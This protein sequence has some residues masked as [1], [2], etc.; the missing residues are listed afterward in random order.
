MVVILFLLSS[1]PFQHHWI[2]EYTFLD[3]D[4]VIRPS[5]L[6]SY[7]ILYALGRPAGK[8]VFLRLCL[9]IPVLIVS[10]MY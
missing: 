2:I 8:Q 4:L 9:T 6:L 5:S 10:F 3:L 7:T 1:L